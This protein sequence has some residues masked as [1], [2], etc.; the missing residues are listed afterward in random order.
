MLA[1]PYWRRGVWWN[2]PKGPELTF[3]EQHILAE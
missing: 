2:F 1:F 3:S